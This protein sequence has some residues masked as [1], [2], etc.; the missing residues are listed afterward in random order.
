MQTGLNILG[1]YLMGGKI[2]LQLADTRAMRD[3][4]AGLGFIAGQ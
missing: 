3:I 1:H 4:R 2:L